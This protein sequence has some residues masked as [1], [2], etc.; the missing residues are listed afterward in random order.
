MPDE[1]RAAADIVLATP[2]DAARALSALASVLEREAP[3]DRRGQESIR[4]NTTAATAAAATTI[5]VIAQNPV[6]SPPLMAVAASLIPKIPATAPM[7][8]RMTVTP[9]S[10]FMITDRLLL[11][12]VR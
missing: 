4:R 1:V 9:V 3:T 6:P 5:A 11:T 10:R 2:H 8:A 7:P 12:W